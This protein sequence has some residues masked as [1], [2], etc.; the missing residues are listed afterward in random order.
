MD[1]LGK[2]NYFLW[3]KFVVM[4]IVVD[5][6]FCMVFIWVVVVFGLLV[7]WLWKF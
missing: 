7:G 3:G 1:L 2:V 6:M 5:M 4:E